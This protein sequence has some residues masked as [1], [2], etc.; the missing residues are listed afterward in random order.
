MNENTKSGLNFISIEARPLD[1]LP[2]P[3]QRG[4]SFSTSRWGME[5]RHGGNALNTVRPE[6]PV[7]RT[8]YVGFRLVAGLDPAD[9]VSPR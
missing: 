7:V 9:R 6:R 1:Q 5:N 8:A 4:L 3:R 2:L